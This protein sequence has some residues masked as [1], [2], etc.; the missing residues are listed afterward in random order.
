M[1]PLMSWNGLSF[2]LR[3]TTIHMVSNCGNII[4]VLDPSVVSITLKSGQ[5]HA[6]SLTAVSSQS[7]NSSLCVAH[8]LVGVSA[9]DRSKQ[10]DAPAQ[11]V[12]PF[13]LQNLQHPLY[14]QSM[15]DISSQ[16]LSTRM[17]VGPY[18]TEWT[19]HTLRSAT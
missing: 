3:L 15:V 13:A 14:H 11:P 1:H 16:C 6:C 19:A 12:P 8:H 18:T 10:P 4:E 17:L 9:S 5:K 2:P 7:C